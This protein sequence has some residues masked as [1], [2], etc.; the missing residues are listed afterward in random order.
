[1]SDDSFIRE[2][3]E[4]LRSARFQ[5][6]W[7]KY[8]K[9][10]IAAAVFIVVA[11]AG[12][13]YWEY[14]KGQ[15]AARSGDAFMAAVRLAEAGKQDEAVKAFQA[16]ESDSADTYRIMA[17][18]RTASEIA[19]K[20]ETDEAVKKYDAIAADKSAEENLRSIARIRAGMLLVDTG[21]VTEVE[22]RVGPLS[23]PGAPYRLSAREALGLAYYKA[24]DLENAFKQFETIS[25]DSDAPA[26]IRQRMRIMHD[27]I[28][29]NGGPVLEN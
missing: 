16:L 27:L 23:G 2:V 6:F 5:D 29:S 3:D 17:L 25:K 15:E 12:Y 28:A 7:S 13:R 8:G 14:S 4:E 22:A 18:M 19:A 20:G 26:A 24:G 11:T 21:T 10:L 1:M 9:I